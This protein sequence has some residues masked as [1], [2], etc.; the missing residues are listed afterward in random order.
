MLSL[1]KSLTFNAKKTGLLRAAT[2]CL[3]AG[4]TSDTSGSE[5]AGPLLSWRTEAEGALR[6][7]G[8]WLPEGVRLLCQFNRS[9]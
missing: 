8:H 3:L 2:G 4:R 1:P 9:F 6:G 5:T 7:Y